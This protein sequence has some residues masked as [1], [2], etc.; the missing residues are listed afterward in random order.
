MRRGAGIPRYPQFLPDFAEL[1]TTFSTE[2]CTPKWARTSMFAPAKPLTGIPQQPHHHPT[3]SQRHVRAVLHPGTIV[4]VP[5][6]VVPVMGVAPR[7][8]ERR[9]C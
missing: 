9:G 5:V 3:R 1:S 4:V 7:R 8:E 6:Y 2:I